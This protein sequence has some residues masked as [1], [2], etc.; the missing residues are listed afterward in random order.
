M[1]KLGLYGVY[2]LLNITYNLFICYNAIRLYEILTMGLLN[3]FGSRQKALLEA[4]LH[5]RTGISVDELAGHLNISR[6]ATN[7]HLSSLS[8]LDLIDSDLRPSTGG[9]PVRGYFLSSS[10]LELFPRRYTDFSKFLISW[11]R[12]NN[13]GQ[14]LHNCLSE[15]GN[16]IAQEFVP[17]VT[18]L[19][20]LALKIGEVASIMNELGYESTTQTTDDGASEI[21]ASNCVYHQVAAEC[22]QVC[23]LDLSLME[24][25]LEARVDHQECMVRGGPYCRFEITP[26]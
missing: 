14:S 7:Q 21:I 11:I 13:G 12:S 17:R 4:L 15:L 3:T 18:G 19:N 22:E 23:E 26:R 25:L 24:T 5:H 20:S 1:A 10:G 2:R 16:T 9:R 8:R 6:N